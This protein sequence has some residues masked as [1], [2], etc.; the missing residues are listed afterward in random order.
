M[1][2]NHGQTALIDFAPISHAARHLKLDP[3]SRVMEVLQNLH[4]IDATL[5]E[6]LMTPTHD[7]L[8]LLAMPPQ[9]SATEP[10]TA[11]LGRLFDLLVGR[12]RY[13]VVDCSGRLDN[14]TRLLADLSDAVLLVAQTDVVSLWGATHVR[15]FLGDSV[16]LKRLRLVLNRYKEIPGFTEEDIEKATGC[17]I[18]WKLPNNDRLIASAIDKGV[19]A[20]AH[21]DEEL[22]HSF[23]ALADLLAGDDGVDEAGEADGPGIPVPSPRGRGQQLGFPADDK[24]KARMATLNNLPQQMVEKQRQQEEQARREWE[25]WERW[26]KVRGSRSKTARKPR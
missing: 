26:R 8:R 25:D 11:E 7:G 12:Y 10:T 3:S 4:R 23:C 1:Q 18:L 15:S 22:S 24:D 17:K 9:P 16:N 5:L 19:P 6:R 2:R 14:T 21:A 20:A 13:V